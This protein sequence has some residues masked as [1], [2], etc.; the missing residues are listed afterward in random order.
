MK[1]LVTG[2]AGYIGSHMVRT[3]GEKGHDVVVYDNLSTGHRDSVLS[4]R[5]VTADLADSDALNKLFNSESFNAV[6]HFAAHIVVEESVR[7]PV[8]YYRN[9]FANALNL[10]EACVKHS[11]NQ[12]IFS[13]T[14]AVYGIPEEVP[15]DE[16]APLS[17]INPYG[18]SKFMVEQALKDI[19]LAYGLRYVSLRYFNVAGAD[20]MSR[21]GQKYRD[22]THLITLALRTALGKRHNLDIYGTDYDTP[23][24]TCIRDYIH[25]DDLIDAHLL[26][27]DYLSS[28]KASRVFNCGYGHGYSVREVVDRVK[29]VT[30]VDFMVRETGR[31]AGDPPSLIA[32]SSRIK[33]ELGWKPSYD[34]LEYIIKTAWEWE[35]KLQG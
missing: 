11:V 20:P 33:K 18:A 15:V 35:K 26:A 32:D 17:P 24:G 29:K 31:R 5:L 8:K 25:V 22:P 12:F 34:D 21:I 1:I 16:D 7:N 13:S 2:G 4:G 9:N 30:G 19:S 28:G 10:I 27:L 6:M 23:D 14:A 3:L